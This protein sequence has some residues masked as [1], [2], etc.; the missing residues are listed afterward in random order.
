MAALKKDFEALDQSGDPEVKVAS[1]KMSSL[2]EQWDLLHKLVANR[3]KLAMNYVNFHKK[4]Q[5]V[6]NTKLISYPTCKSLCGHCNVK[7]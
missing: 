7:I 5:Q 6:S 2:R 1:E 3:I 4:A